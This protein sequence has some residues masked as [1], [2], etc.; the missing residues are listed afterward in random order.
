MKV[1]NVSLQLSPDEKLLVGKLAEHQNKIYFEYSP[2]FLSSATP[3]WLS[4]YQLP[5]K[6]GAFE[7][8]DLD[9]GPIFGLFD[10][11]L[12]DGWGLLLMDRYLRGQGVNVESL[13]ILD[14]L[15]FLGKTTMGALVY[16]PAIEHEAPEQLLDLQAL[17]EQSKKILESD[18][19]EIIPV[20]MRIGGSPGGARPKILVGLNS[21]QIMSGAD[22]LPKGFEH[23]IIKFP[24]QEDFPDSGQI[25]YAYSLMAKEA[26]ILMPETRLFEVE[27]GKKYF[28]IKRFDR[29]GNKRFHVH[30]LGNLIHSNFRRPECDY[31]TFFK[32]VSDITKNQVDVKRAFKQMVFNII[33]NN[34]DDHVK[35]FAFMIDKHQN[36]TLTPAY[37]LMYSNGPGGEHTMS[38]AGVGR[39]PNLSD[40]M[41]A[42]KVVGLSEKQ[43]SLIAEQVLDVTQQW[44]AHAETAKVSSES[45]EFI[46]KK[47]FENTQLFEFNPADSNIKLSAD[48]DEEQGP[49]PG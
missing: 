8:R 3:L 23:W 17:A 1:L 13:S 2:E 45:Q 32:V 44:A 36:W 26:G 18:T 25:E 46:Q 21:N 49:S 19:T 30:T 12:P 47:I 9:Y 31:Q 11:S 15:S 39:A 6:S 16:E 48:Q 24:S 5:L 33:T 14:R 28:G 40:A 41:A 42:G 35:N 10:D 22:D 4:P 27:S 38:V 34:K 37:D 20:L 29:D 7:H 43:M